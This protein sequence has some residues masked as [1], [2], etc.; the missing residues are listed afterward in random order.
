[1]T[2]Q[3]VAK[4]DRRVRTAEAAAITGLDARTLQEKAAQGLIPGARKVFGRWT[5]DPSILAKLGNAP[6]PKSC[7]KGYTGAVKSSGRA[8]RSGVSSIERAYELVLSQSRKSA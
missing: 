5:Y 3:T 1:M 7:R 2:I 4:P 8:S 6:C